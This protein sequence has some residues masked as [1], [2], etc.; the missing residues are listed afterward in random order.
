MV[1][2]RKIKEEEDLSKANGTSYHGRC[3]WCSINDIVSVFGKPHYT[4]P[5]SEKAQY[6]W[7]LETSEGNIITLYDWKQHRNFDD[8]E[9]ICWHIGSHGRQAAR[10]GEELIKMEINVRNLLNND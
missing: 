2:I 6:E 7:I 10:L 1:T 9:V 4:S 5:K 8:D 3:V